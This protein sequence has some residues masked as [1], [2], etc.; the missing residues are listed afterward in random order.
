MVAYNHDAL[1]S[2]TLICVIPRFPGFVPSPGMVTKVSKNIGPVSA[3]EE[4]H[5]IQLSSKTAIYHYCL[6]PRVQSDFSLIVYSSSPFIPG[7]D[8]MI[9]QE[10]VLKAFLM[11]R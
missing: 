8:A 1:P 9:L 10:T 5:S 3:L 4:Y 7:L 6:S 11:L 2:S